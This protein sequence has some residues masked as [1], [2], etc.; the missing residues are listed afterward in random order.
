MG[1]VVA[2]LVLLVI[3]LVIE[4]KSGLL[5]EGEKA[6]DFEVR[7]SDGQTFRLKNVEGKK[8]VVLFFY[9][10]DF[11]AGCTAQ[12]CS[13]RDGYSELANLDAVMFGVSGDSSRSHNLFRAEHNLPFELIADTDRML[14]NAF[15]VERLGGL[16]KIPKRVTYVID[17]GG[18]IRLVAHHEFMMEKHLD[19]VLQTLR[20]RAGT[21]S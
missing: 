9:P 5:Q 7:L 14:I 11:T 12:A 20:R 1:V 2:V 3:G 19:D 17:K 16:L 8:N 10:K 6:P 13:M 18:V 21:G 15:G 4:E